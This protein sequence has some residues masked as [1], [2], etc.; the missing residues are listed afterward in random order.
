MNDDVP[1]AP[2]SARRFRLPAWLRIAVS[3]GV[4]GWVASRTEWRQLGGV[5]ALDW[6]LTVPAVLLAGLAYPLQAWRWQRLLRTQA[7]P[8]PARRVHVLFWVGNFYNSFLPGGVAGDGVRIYSAAREHPGHSARIAASVLADRLLGFGTLLMLAVLALG[9]R[10]ATAGAPT[11]LETL[12]VAS[13]GTLALLVA[14]AALALRSHLWLPLAERLLGPARAAELGAATEALARDRSGLVVA[15]TLSVAVWLL[16]FAAL[17]CLGHAVGLAV[18]PLALSAAAAAAY[19]AAALPIS[20]GGHGVREGTLVLVLGW[21][22][23]GHGN[24]ASL[25]LL[26]VAFWAV[27]TGWSVIGALAFLLPD[28]TSSASG[29]RADGQLG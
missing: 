21:L 3:L 9:A 20:V 10:L 17:G 24:P 2:A 13:A 16:D 19:V 4:L 14:G 25:A 8:I 29:Q 11:E 18:D 26:A 5:T 1:V 22:G 28:A 6:S 15:T 12:F 23:A 27:S 7:V